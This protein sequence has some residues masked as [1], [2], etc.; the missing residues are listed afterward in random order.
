MITVL[1]CISLYYEL[2]SR[3]NEKCLNNPQAAVKI[4]RRGWRDVIVPV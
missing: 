2:S 3:P 1:I 4:S